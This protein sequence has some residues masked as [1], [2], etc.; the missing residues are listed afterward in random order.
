M[1]FFTMGM[2]RYKL[3]ATEGPDLA[4]DENNDNSMF[5]LKGYNIAAC[6][7][8]EGR[9]QHTLCTLNVQLIYNVYYQQKPK[10][11]RPCT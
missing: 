11:R 7:E 2:L 8:Y 1:I 5:Q 9:V 3:Y 4:V 10:P 6:Y